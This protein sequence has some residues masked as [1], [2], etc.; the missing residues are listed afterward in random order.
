VIYRFDAIF[1]KSLIEFFK[2]TEETNLTFMYNQ[3]RSGTVKVLSKKNKARHITLPD[4]KIYY[5]TLLIKI[6]VISIKNTNGVES[7]EINHTFTIK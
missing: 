5:K 1:I 3:K 2:E 4:V 7:P 6:I